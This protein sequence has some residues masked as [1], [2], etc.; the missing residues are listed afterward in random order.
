MELHQLHIKGTH[1]T[2]NLS[3]RMLCDS[4]A[5]AFSSFTAACPPLLAAEADM[6]NSD[7]EMRTK[8]NEVE[9]FIVLLQ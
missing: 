4:L 9:R 8:A 3:G 1:K 2:E 5:L 6:S 7:I